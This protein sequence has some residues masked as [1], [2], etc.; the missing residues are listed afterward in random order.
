MRKQFIIWL[1]EI[2]QKLYTSLFKKDDTWPVKKSDLLRF[3]SHT[4]GK[5]LGVFL[6]TN[7]FEL[8]PKVERHDAYHTITGLGTHV[9]DEIALQCLCFGN[10]K[11]SIY[12]YGAIIIGT[13]ILPEYYSFYFKAYRI[14]KQAH[15]FHHYDYSQLL[16]VSF[17]EFRSAI[18]SNKLLI[19]LK[20][21]K[22]E[23]IQSL[24]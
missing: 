19:Q 22:H 15:S 13:L 10:G 6:D 1:F 11:R 12:L 9:E 21:L 20:N 8:I 7:N 14:G 18:F 2:S 16:D 3:P 24:L 5:H 23:Q 4:I 17:E